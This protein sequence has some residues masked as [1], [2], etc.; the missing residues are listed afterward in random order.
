MIEEKKLQ[1]R[2]ERNSMTITPEENKLLRAKK[3]CVAGCGGLG[4][5]VIEGLVRI[6]VGTVR[7]IDGDVFDETNLNRQVLSN[8]GNL[9]RSKAEE[10]VLQMKLINSEVRIDPVYAF[11]DESNAA[12]LIRGFDA[13]VDALDN[14]SSRKTLERACEAENIPLVHGAIAGWNGQV[15][16]IMPGDNLI[17]SLYYDCEDRGE[18]TETGNPSFTPAVIS[19]IEAA[20]VIKILL[21]KQGALKSSM[22]MIDLLN[23]QYDVVEF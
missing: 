3:V 11:I 20:E 16:V 8:E 6:G 14:I 19:A 2:Y 17:S 7:A 18:E 12:E 21:K 5:G 4:G 1:R 22:L 15:S 13:V 9:G 23:H 10:A